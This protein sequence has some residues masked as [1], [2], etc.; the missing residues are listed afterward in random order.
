L[1][2]PPISTGVLGIY[3]EFQTNV[4][5]DPQ[6]RVCMYGAPAKPWAR[7]GVMQPYFFSHLGEQKAPK[8]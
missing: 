4:Q 3:L 5:E 8:I 2:H 7:I 6:F 1:E